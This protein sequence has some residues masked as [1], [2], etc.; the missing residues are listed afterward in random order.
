MGHFGTP[1]SSS[2]LKSWPAA[3]LL[4]TSSFNGITG[5]VCPYRSPL[6]SQGFALTNGLTQRTWSSN[7]QASGPP[8]ITSYRTFPSHSRGP[9]TTSSYDPPPYTPY[10]PTSSRTPRSTPHRTNEPSRENEPTV[11]GCGPVICIAIMLIEAVL[12]ICRSDALAT[13]IDLKSATLRESKEREKL[14]LERERLRRERELWERAREDRVPQGAFWEVISPSVDCRGYGRREYWGILRN[15]PQ[16]WTAID[17]CMNMPAEI[18]GVTVRRPNW[19]AF[20]GG[21]PHIVGHWMVDWDQT[22]CKPWY[23]DFHD[24]VSLIPPLA[25]I[26]LRLRSHTSGVYKSRGRYPSNRGAHRGYT[27]PERT[28]LAGDVRDHPIGLEP[29]HLQEPYSLRS[30]SG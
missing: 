24:A 15:I 23:K 7:N 13:F 27:R 4:S 11:I 9:S 22:D 28:R 29:D 10:I 19:C 1:R 14:E 20:V 18:K 17:A 8:P 21:S 12:I 26:T 2:A 6:N 16:G 5:S 3:P 30:K 25:H